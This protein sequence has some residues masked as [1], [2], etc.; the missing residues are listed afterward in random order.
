[1]LRAPV[2][3]EYNYLMID[4]LVI[5]IGRLYCSFRCKTQLIKIKTDE[6]AN[7]SKKSIYS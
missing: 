7:I 1:M 3:T 2:S 5:L 4:S 6:K